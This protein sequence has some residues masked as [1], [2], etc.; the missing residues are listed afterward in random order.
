MKFIIL[1]NIIDS[2]TRLQVLLGLKLTG[3]TDTLTEAK[4]LS[5][6]FYRRSEIENEQQYRNDLDEIY[7]IQKELRSK[8]TQQLAIN[9][10]PKIEEHTL[11]VMDKP[12]DEAKL[13]QPLP[14]YNKQ[15]EIAIRLPTGYNGIFNVTSKKNLFHNIK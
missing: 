15:F 10:R 5:H 12:P 8:F 6:E 1:S 4:N 11:F 3:H 14:S 9:T 7:T 2:W 13:S